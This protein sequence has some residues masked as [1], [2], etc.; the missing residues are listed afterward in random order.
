[1]GDEIPLEM[2]V[3]ATGGDSF[4][5]FDVA[6][7]Y[8][9]GDGVAQDYEKAREWLLKAAE[10]GHSRAKFNLGTMHL[11]GVGVAEDA[12]QALKWY[13]SAFEGAD[14]EL[15]FNIGEVVEYEQTKL[16]AWPF[17]VKCYRAAADAGHAKAQVMLGIRLVRGLGIEER[18]DLGE[19]YITEAARQGEPK[20]LYVLAKMYQE[21]FGREPDAAQAV[22]LLYLAA[23][24]GHP[25]A[26]AEGKALAETLSDEQQQRVSERIAATMER[27]KKQAE[28][29]GPG[30]S[31]N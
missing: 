2:M 23:L 15:L 14:S 31:E 10:Q 25:D 9:R 30:F 22:Y 6:I 11:K 12:K 19:Y 29:R 4:A 20:A 21:G 1:M 24:E 13:E 28:E 16:N 7:R 27:L 26:Q 17:A 3:A 8:L 5:Q 18:P